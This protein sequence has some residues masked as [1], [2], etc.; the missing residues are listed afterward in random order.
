MKETLWQISCVL[1]FE[2]L[3]VF[4][5][6][7]DEADS[8]TI[9]EIEKGENK[10]KWDFTAFYEEKPDLAK[11]DVSLNLL[12]DSYGLPVPMYKA[13]EIENKNWLL[14]NVKQLQPITAGRFYVYGS[15]I[16]N[17]EVP[18]GLIPL[19]VDATTAFGSGKHFTTKSCLIMFDKLL[20]KGFNPDT[21]LDMG[22]GT[23]ILAIAAAKAL[24]K[25]VLAV[26]IDDEAVR[27][28]IKTIAD[29][30][31]SDLVSAEVGNGYAKG[32][33]AESGFFDLVFQ[34]ILAGPLVDMA[35][36]LCNHL[37]PKGKAILSG[38]LQTQA[39]WVVQAHTEAGLVLEE[40]FDLDE[41]STL[42]V[43]K[44]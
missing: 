38:L 12:A 2:E 13:E 11:I 26:D 25:K 30:N 35:G 5:S 9:Q 3:E 44:P 27:V 31:V 32:S 7:F 16:V 1:S 40:R 21:I 39:D 8:T 4:E 42:V 10:G 6:A 34:N 23:G 29:N 14:E 24:G 18:Q 41:W 36:D 33:S 22:C 19:Q 15:H 37:Q 17:P 43:G 20:S 28:A